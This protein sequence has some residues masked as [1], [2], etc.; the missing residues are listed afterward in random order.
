MNASDIHENMEVV[1]SCGHHIG[2]VDCVD[3][4]SVRLKRS[5]ADDR[6]H[7]VALAW[8]ESVGQTVRL[9]KTH[10]EAMREWQAQPVWAGGG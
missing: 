4:A 7:Y 6:P 9:N 8:V 2:I 10:E 5:G 1:G 3:G